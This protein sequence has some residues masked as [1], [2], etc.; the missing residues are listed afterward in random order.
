MFQI[1]DPRNGNVRWVATL[2]VGPRGDR[3]VYKRVCRTREEA[4][5]ALAGFPRHNE[6]TEIER[7]WQYVQKGPGC[8]LWTGTRT[9]RGYGMF[10][11]DGHRKRPAHRYSLELALGEKLPTHI[12]ACHH[13]DNPPCVRPDHLY[14]GTQ[15]D[16]MADAKARGRLNTEL[17]VAVRQERRRERMREHYADWQAENRGVT[18]S[19]PML[20]AIGNRTPR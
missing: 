2:Q 14:A 11:L 20:P 4:E 13:C 5:A 18:E 1:V 17:A 8:W 15:A 6:R 3:R 16:N 9:T 10:S 19:S 7:F 12:Y